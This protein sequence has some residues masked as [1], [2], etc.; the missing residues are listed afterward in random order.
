MTLMSRLAL[1]KEQTSNFDLI[2]TGHRRHHLFSFVLSSKNGDFKFGN[3]TKMYIAHLS[4]I[5]KHDMTSKQCV[6]RSEV[7]K[8]CRCS[9]TKEAQ[10]YICGSGAYFFLV[11]FVESIPWKTSLVP[12][13]DA[14]DLSKT[15]PHIYDQ[16]TCACSSCA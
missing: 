16:A 7:N 11:P 2:N 9:T 5:I 8:T 3:A 6:S 1:E 13:H 4:K 14:R 10:F 12:W 15:Y